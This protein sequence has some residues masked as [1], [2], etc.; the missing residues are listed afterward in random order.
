MD[1]S[2]NLTS[3]P[4]DPVYEYE[5]LLEMF[6]GFEYFSYNQIQYVYHKINGREDE[7]KQYLDLCLEE[8]EKLTRKAHK[9]TTP[10]EN[11]TS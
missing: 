4:D 7:A 6:G 3:I 9:M 1:S 2:A 8:T 5:Q 10:E 11:I